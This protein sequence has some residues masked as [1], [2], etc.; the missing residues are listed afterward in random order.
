MTAKKKQPVGK[1]L[2]TEEQI[3]KRAAEL[4]QQITKDYDGEELVCI[5]TLKGSVLW[6]AD[7][8][9]NIDMDLEI[10]FISASSYGSSTISSG[11]VK[12]SLDTE[13]NL[14]NKHILI[15]EDIVDTG[16]TLKFLVEKFEE[17]GPKSIKV[18]T[19]L[20]KKARRTNNF[21][22]DYIG[23]DVE[24]LFLIGYGLDYD[25]IYR[26]LPYVSFLEGEVE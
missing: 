14:Y 22:A 18:C 8:I 2:Y 3:R 13:L 24:D 4:G 1:V 26:N 23:F 25:Q 10:D 15:I 7:V 17:R 21:T 6:F 12:I 5:G 9:K 20:D 19:M 11:V 16:T